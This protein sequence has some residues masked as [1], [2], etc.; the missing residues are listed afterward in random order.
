MKPVAERHFS[1]LGEH[2]IDE[3]IRASLRDEGLRKCPSLVV[4][5]HA[6]RG[7]SNIWLFVSDHPRGSWISLR[8]ISSNSSGVTSAMAVANG[9]EEE[10]ANANGST[11]P[12]A[13]VATLTSSSLIG[14]PGS[15]SL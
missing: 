5:C 4:V 9:T 2:A 15:S 7:R 1:T 10:G 8:W 12:V 13:T 6:A 14:S 11:L 3:P